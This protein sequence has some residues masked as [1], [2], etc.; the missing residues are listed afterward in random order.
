MSFYVKDFIKLALEQNIPSTRKV[1]LNEIIDYIKSKID[2]NQEINLN[3]IC[4]HN[5]R[6][7][8]C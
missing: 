8:Y 6:R 7:S 5:S 2:K 3:F 1:L 4:T